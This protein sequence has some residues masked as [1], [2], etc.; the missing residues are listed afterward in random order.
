M[1]NQFVGV[2][3][4]I[5][6]KKEKL[7]MTNTAIEQRLISTNELAR[8]INKLDV[9]YFTGET[10]IQIHDCQM[11]E[12]GAVL[13][14]ID[15]TTTVDAVEVVRCENC[16][17]STDGYICN[18]TGFMMPPHPTYPDWFCSCGKNIE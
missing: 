7:Y 10:D 18:G 2:I 13:A 9:F 8:K 12:L 16:T 17:F 11:V 15:E 14:E 4:R 6:Y 3:V 1:V 5:N